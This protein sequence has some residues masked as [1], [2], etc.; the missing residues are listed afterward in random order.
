MLKQSY[1]RETAAAV[2]WYPGGNLSISSSHLHSS[3]RERNP[4]INSN[5]GARTSVV[6]QKSFR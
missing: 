1:K 6:D 3:A 2:S 4:R 5:I